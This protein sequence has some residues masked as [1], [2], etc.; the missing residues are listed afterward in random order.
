MMGL[1]N[2]ESQL[3]ASWSAEPALRCWPLEKV[4]TLPGRNMR[5]TL[6]WR[7]W[8]R[9][10]CGLRISNR[11]RKWVSAGPCDTVLADLSR[12]SSSPRWL[13]LRGPGNGLSGLCPLLPRTQGAGMGFLLPG[14]RCTDPY[15]LFLGL[16]CSSAHRTHATAY[17]LPWLDGRVPGC[18]QTFERS[19][20]TSKGARPVASSLPRVSPLAPS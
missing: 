12:R 15:D 16:H 14:Q 1:S 19:E 9:S 5:A 18:H 8:S 2:Q 6:D 11:P 7:L 10:D 3:C 20:Y 17:N 13:L 4:A